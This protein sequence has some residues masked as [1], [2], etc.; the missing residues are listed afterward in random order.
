MTG[1]E[2]FSTQNLL[3]VS[4]GHARAR[5]HTHTLKKTHAVTHS[6]THTPLQTV[7]HTTHIH[8]LF[9]GCVGC[10]LWGGVAGRGA[11]NGKIYTTQWRPRQFSKTAQNNLIYN[12]YDEAL[13]QIV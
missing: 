7:T 8:N 1:S 13:R 2:S 5:T 11:F 10:G 9:G 3:A 12:G 6:L 4:V